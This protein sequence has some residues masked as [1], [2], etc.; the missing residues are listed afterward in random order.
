MRMA[1]MFA[2]RAVGMAAAATIG[3]VASGCA[4]PGEAADDGRLH[5]VATS[6]PLAFV[7]ERIGGPDV[8]VSDL[9]AAGADSHD[10]ELTPRQVSRIAQAD[11]VVF[12]SNYQPAVADVVGQHAG[13]ATLDVAT[14]D[15][16]PH[17]WLDPTELAGIAQSVGAALGKVVPERSAQLD[18]RAAVL[19]D[20]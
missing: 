16:D 4:T 10:L 17:G 19:V 15:T 9:T 3:A 13:G 12:Q 20:E 18:Q 11:L 5:V 7:A 2:R 6:Y 8:Q 1:L 14:G